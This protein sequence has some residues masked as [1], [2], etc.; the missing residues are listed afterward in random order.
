MGAIYSATLRIKLRNAT[1]RSVGRRLYRWMKDQENPGKGNFV[2]GVNWCLG[3]SRKA[4]IWPSSLAGACKILLAFHQGDGRHSVEDGFDVFRNAFKATYSWG[5][6][7]EEAFRSMSW[8]L[9]KG[10]SLK[11]WSDNDHVWLEM[12]I[13]G[14]GN[15][16][17]WERKGR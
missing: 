4:G 7:M 16:V 10:S 14:N 17:V 15:P 6:L 9:E 13:D 1:K 3:E 11:Y 8:A 2:L 5:T 12:G